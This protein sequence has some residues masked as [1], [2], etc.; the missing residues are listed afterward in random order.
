VQASRATH[1]AI[2]R[3]NVAVAS[4]QRYAVGLEVRLLGPRHPLIRL[5]RASIRRAPAGVLFSIFG[6]NSGNV[7]LQNVRG[8]ALITHG[9]RVVARVPVGP[10]TFVTRTSIAY[11]I[12]TPGEQPREG[13]VYRVRARMRYRGGVA[14]LDTLVR[15]GHA[16]AVRQQGFGGPR[17][18]AHHGFPTA[19]VA[20]AALV[21][22]LG[23][24]VPWRLWRGV[25]RSPARFL[26]GALMAARD[27]GGPLSLIV[28]A[29][30]GAG[31]AAKRRVSSLVRSRL[32]RSDRLCRLDDQGFI[33]I[34]PDTDPDTAEALAAD[35][36]RHLDRQEDRYP[37]NGSNGVAIEVHAAD[38][39][40]TAAELLE[41]VS[42][43]N[44]GAPAP[45]ALR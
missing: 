23:A 41:R 25:S 44:R 3:S 12:L 9:A 31:S 35:L 11:P 43:T 39:D 29:T 1:Q 6:R 16:D 7:I 19:L 8:S 42:H 4:V 26:D 36:R 15:F 18:S 17:A 20:L 22:A 37:G 2:V 45:K 40:A 34:A 24:A 14:R 27:G 13:T 21:L 30:N 33:V 5:S 28:V 32:R 38:G 10:G